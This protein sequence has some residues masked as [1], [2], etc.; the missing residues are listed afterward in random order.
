M[1]KI[2]FLNLPYKFEISRAS[3]WPE[4]TKSG[5][6]YY[7]YWLCYAAGVCIK[8]GHEVD[9]VD[10]ITKK[11]TTQETVDYVKNS[12]AN[13]VMGEITTS[14]CSHDYE[15]ITEIKK[16]CP[17]IQIIIGGTHAT[18]L[19]EQVLEEC[20]AIDIVVMHNFLANMKHTLVFSYCKF[21][22]LYRF[23]LK[24]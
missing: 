11:M 6:L 8:K 9:L 24:P 22:L 13:Y 4:K 21:K 17:N 5:T 23:S 10:C 12:S 14:T 3:R 20:Q 2:L 19:S 1:K 18:S 7:P 16:N 15:V